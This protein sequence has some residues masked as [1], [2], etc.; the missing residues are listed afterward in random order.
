M[1]GTIFATLRTT[2][3]SP[4]RASKMTSGET[5]ESE[6]PITITSG[7]CPVSASSR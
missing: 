1:G 5:R 4:G 7:A 6:Q 3:S 2:N